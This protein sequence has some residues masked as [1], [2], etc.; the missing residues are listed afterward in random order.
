MPSEVQAPPTA[1]TITIVR[2]HTCCT[3]SIH[4]DISGGAHG[5]FHEDVRVVSDLVLTIDGRSPRLVSAQRQ[6]PSQAQWSYSVPRDARELP[7]VALVRTRKLTDRLEER[8]LLRAEHR[9]IC[10]V[11][12]SLQI[13]ADFADLLDVRSGSSNGTATALTPDGVPR[14]ERHGE[15]TVRANALGAVTVTEGRVNL[16]LR[17]GDPTYPC[18][19]DIEVS[20]CTTRRPASLPAETSL[21]VPGAVRGK[22]VSQEA[23]AGGLRV[24][25]A[26]RW[27]RSIESSAADLDALRI[28]A[29]RHQ[30]GYIGAGAPWYLALFG[31]DALLTAWAALIATGYT[32]GLDVC[33]SL[34][35][36][37]GRSTDERTA[38]QPGR[39]LHELRTGLTGVFGLPPGT[40]YFGSVDATPLFVM[41]LAEL[42][43]WGAP[44]HR[45]RALLPA[46]RRAI[47]WCSTYGDLDGDGFIEYPPH[48]EG[49]VNQGWKDSTDAMVHADGSLAEGPIAPAEVQA[50][51]YADQRG[52]Y[53]PAEAVVEKVEET[54]TTYVYEGEPVNREYGKMGKSLKNI[55]TPDEMYEA[56]GADT[57]RVYEMSMGPLDVYR[58]GSPPP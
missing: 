6:G 37:Q 35:S 38:E 21:G 25:G 44:D 46:A 51:A 43:R 55:V 56:Y 13:A 24:V 49:L 53:V 1:T 58:R 10:A 54:E 16:V 15:I 31:R 39:I 23:R 29:S 33:E 5:M 26:S 11:E 30:L 52:Q 34:A 20:S 42:H 17:C 50:Y 8:L 40:A 19:L 3:S 9:Q 18:G 41:L 48:H 36:Y 57:F 47:D 4:G 27:G 2:G 45:I 12:V 22:T 7:G 14:L 28:E 32:Q